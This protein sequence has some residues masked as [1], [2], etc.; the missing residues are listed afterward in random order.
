M[1]LPSLRRT[2]ATGAAGPD[3]QRI[4]TEYVLH[5]SITCLGEEDVTPLYE[6]YMKDSRLDDTAKA[7]LTEVY[8]S[9]HPRT[10]PAL[11]I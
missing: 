2:K 9:L 8:Q 6:E 5:M 7:E 3:S 1:R 10:P 4:L 11:V